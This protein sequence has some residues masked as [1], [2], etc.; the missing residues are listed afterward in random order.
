MWTVC[1]NHQMYT[2]LNAIKYKLQTPPPP[3]KKKNLST[4]TQGS[5]NWNESMV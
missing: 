3:K 5:K 4:V 1:N 2:A